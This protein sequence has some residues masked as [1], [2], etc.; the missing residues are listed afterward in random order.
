MIFNSFVRLGLFFY[1]EVG[2]NRSRFTAAMLG[3]ALVCC[4]LCGC[5]PSTVGEC[6]E[7]GAAAANSADWQRALKLA[8]RG[9]RLAPDNVDALLL[10]AVAAWRC[11]K[12]EEALAAATRAADID[13]GNFT[14]RYTQGRIAMAMPGHR[15]EAVAALRAALKLRRGDRDTLIELCNLGAEENSP[16]TLGFLKLLAVDPEFAESPALYNQLGV[17]YLRRK[18]LTRAKR[19][20]M[21][22]WKLDKNDPVITYNIACFFD[23]YTASPRVAARLYGDYLRLT[24][25]DAAAEPTRKVA[26]ARLEVLGGAR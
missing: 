8:S 18:D 6:L 5:G 2:M 15:A 13:S 20:F 3:A 11:G 24:A 12:L 17:E 7:Q 10:K 16:D 4:G 26:A 1:R 9:V 22:A 25:G 14:A 19:A 23:R 21:T